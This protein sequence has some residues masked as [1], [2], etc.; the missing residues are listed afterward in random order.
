MRFPNTWDIEKL[1][2]QKL[3]HFSVKVLV[4]KMFQLRL[5][6]TFNFKAQHK[7]TKYKLLLQTCVQTYW[8]SKR[9]VKRVVRMYAVV[10]PAI[11]CHSFPTFALNHTHWLG[12]RRY[13]F[14]SCMRSHYFLSQFSDRCS[15]YILENVC[16]LLKQPEQLNKS[17]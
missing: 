15:M 14:V 10:Y 2:Q 5:F 13:L 8:Q 16:Y 11:N 12:W 6:L 1:G 3:S 17:S 9:V 7:K 4:E